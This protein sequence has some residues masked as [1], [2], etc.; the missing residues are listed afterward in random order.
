MGAVAPKTNS[1]TMNMG[2]WGRKRAG[3]ASN[4][5]FSTVAFVIILAQGRQTRDYDVKFQR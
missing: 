5:K 2:K 4:S 1:K 3:S